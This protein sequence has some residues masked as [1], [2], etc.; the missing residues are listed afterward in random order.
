MYP[1]ILR[2][3][4]TKLEEVRII[5]ISFS[6]I[7]AVAFG[8]AWLIPLWVAGSRLERENADQEDRQIH[9]FDMVLLMLDI[10]PLFW[11]FRTLTEVPSAYRAARLE[12]QSHPSIRVMFWLSLVSAAIAVGMAFLPR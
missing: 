10:I 7:F 8:L 12:W 6:G 1:D 3:L 11:A 2:E 5:V 9:L 4:V